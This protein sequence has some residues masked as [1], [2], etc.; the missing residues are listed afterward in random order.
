MEKLIH[1]K[2][3][4]AL[5]FTALI[6][7][8]ARG[9]EY[10]TKSGTPVIPAER[11]AVIFTPAAKLSTPAEASAGTYIIVTTPDLKPSLRQFIQWKKRQGFHVEILCPAT[12]QRDSIRA[13][14]AQHYR[15]A[16]IP[17]Y[18]LLVGDVDRIPSFWG[19]YQPGG[20]GNHVTD[21]Y[22]GE[23]TGDYV[24]EAFVGRLSATDS[25][26]L[27]Q[28]VAKIIAYEQGHWAANYSQLLLVAGNESRSTAPVTTNG[29]THY[30]SQLTALHRPGTDTAC[31]YNPGS[32]NS[33]D[34]ILAALEQGNLLVNYTAHCLSN[35]WS[36]PSITSR[37]F[38]TL[39]NPIPAVFVNNC[40]LSNAFNGTCFGEELLRR[41]QGGAVAVIGATNETLWD[42]DYFWAV[43]A[44]RPP[45]LSPSH[46]TL[47]PGAFDTLITRPGENYTL[48]AMLFAGCKAVSESGSP[49][50]AF[51]W[52]IYN[53]L[54]DPSL[55]PFWTHAD[56]LSL[57][58]PDSLMAG[59]TTLT[60][61]CNTPC[62]ISITQDTTLLATTLT[63]ADGTA[64]L[65]LPTALHGDS[66]TV[67]ATRPEAVCDMVTLPIRQP[68]QPFLAT[69]GFQLNDTLLAVQLKNVGS[70]TAHQHQIH[71]AQDS[72]DQATA[73]VMSRP[74]SCAI[75]QLA[76]QADT[77]LT[78]PLGRLI[79]GEE[80]SL[81]A[82]LTLADS[83]GDP[84]STLHL[85]VALPDRYPRLSRLLLLENDSL[86]AHQLLPDHDYIILTTL[87]HPA[88]SV[89]LLLANIPLTA[90][91]QGSTTYTT[92]F[93][94]SPDLQYLPLSVTSCMDNWHK[95]YSYWL[96]AHHA[97]EPF[98]TGDFTNLPWLHTDTNPWQIDSTAPY[99]GH[100]CARSAKIDNTQK[101]VLSLDI[102]VMSDD[103]ISFHYYVSSEASDWLYFF[104]D[105]RRAGFWSGNSGWQRYSRPVSAGRHRL[106]WIYQKD[107]SGSQRDDC[108]RIDDLRLPL[109][110][111]TQPSGTPQADSTLASFQPDTHPL[112]NTFSIYPNPTKG[113][114]SISFPP[115]TNAHTILVYDIYGRMTDKIKIPSNATSTQY[116]TTHLR[117]G[118]Y[119]LVL[120][121][122]TG[123]YTQ[124]MTVIR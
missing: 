108:A 49:F 10:V 48:G 66:I 13:L 11:E 84:Y 23:Y 47:H 31:F 87:D 89:T 81:H 50:D 58:P 8:S 120:H 69:T 100:Y 59:F 4:S 88:D 116:S 105:N 94:T 112:P 103:T 123:T 1:L 52:E 96:T 68:V 6:A 30:L 82:T 92:N 54:G 16:H 24:P 20:I 93:H 76:P 29:Q 109:A 104:I 62:R 5:I 28:M 114:I 55:I 25:T 44:K 90:T 36:S 86:P 65:S 34:S 33:T 107:A 32:G 121:T 63:A 95:T 111:W 110:L 42:E 124:K 7:L 45:T 101:S 79:Y 46:D 98:E 35:G 12:L 106:Q 17:H 39:H 117:L 113:T 77:T 14:L 9:Q 75:Q 70:L 43:G 60:L 18:V 37:A 119:T 72:A 102:H 3:V 67:T 71:L 118:T 78:I 51:Y 22:Y 122:G 91:A 85:H 40:C 21:L 19:K 80:P 61:H 41:P 26:Q 2:R 27:S 97:T 74:F 83:L 64:T 73:A 115:G 57:T 99:N 56:T 38:D 53:L 15:P